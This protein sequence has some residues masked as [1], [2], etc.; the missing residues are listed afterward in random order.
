MFSVAL[1]NAACT[2]YAGGNW[3]IDAADIC[4]NSSEIIHLSGNLTVNGVL[5]LTSV[6]LI[7][8]TTYNGSIGVIVNAGGSLKL[9]DTDGDASTTNDA[10]NL[11][12]NNSVYRLKFESY[13]G[14]IMTHGF[15]SHIGFSN[16]DNLIN[17]FGIAL[18]SNYSNFTYNTFSN[19]YTG[20]FPGS[21]DSQI[22]F[23]N[24]SYNT[25]N[26]IDATSIRLQNGTNST[27][28][29]NLISANAGFAAIYLSYGS[30][31][32]RV[33]NNSFSSLSGIGV[34]VYLS[35]FNTIENNA[36]QGGTRGI[37]IE[38][39]HN[40]TVTNNTVN[41]STLASMAVYD[42]ENSTIQNN[43][44][45]FSTYDG[46]Y[47]NN[48]S[49][50]YLLYN[51]I[52]NNSRYG[53]YE[54]YSTNNQMFA[55]TIRYNADDGIAVYYSNYST[56]LANSVILPS[57]TASADTAGIHLYAGYYNVLDTNSITKAARQLGIGTS[58]DS[59]AE[60]S[61]NRIYGNNT[62]NAKEVR[63][64]GASEYACPDDASIA[65]GDSNTSAIY[66]VGCD[67]VTVADGTISNG[68]GIALYFTNNSRVDNATVNDS[69]TGAFYYRTENCT[70][71]DSTLY[72][73][74]YGAYSSFNLN[75]TMQR[76]AVTDVTVGFYHFASLLGE[77]SF[78]NVTLADAPALYLLLSIE[79]NFSYNNFTNSLYGAYLDLVSISNTFEA[80]NF[81]YNSIA[82]VYLGN[83]ES[84]VFINNDVAFNNNGY[85]FYYLQNDIRL[86][87]TIWNDRVYNNTVGVY[88]NN[89]SGN[90][91]TGVL[92]DNNSFHAEFN[93]S[94]GNYIANSTFATHLTN[95]TRSNNSASDTLLNNTGVDAASLGF[96]DS[97]SNVTLAYFVNVNVL[98][99]ADHSALSAA[100]SVTSQAS[101]PLY[102]FTSPG[103]NVI[104]PV[105]LAQ[106]ASPV[107]YTPHSFTASRSGFTP[108]TESVSVDPDETV[109]IYLVQLSTGTGSSA[110]STPSPT[111][112]PSPAA[113]ATASPTATIEAAAP[114]PTYA[115]T[116]SPTVT[117]PPAPSTASYPTATPTGQVKVEEEQDFTLILIALIIVAAIV[118]WLWKS[119]KKY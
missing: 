10:F 97:L 86:D 72:N 109:T 6:T 107:N 71:T 63:Y 5:H 84:N 57:T 37:E 33:I 24:L 89:A 67:N 44:F 38:A 51:V 52:E 53:I 8:N 50:G 115:A 13:G 1:A 112:T 85:S 19:M 49:Y 40:N 62:V 20:V 7:A 27:I 91:F 12:A 47:L 83:A 28:E 68:D 32:N 9:N 48:A 77:F 111:P 39:A 74:T 25:F 54:Y 66:V 55:N 79:N 106:M 16:H 108:A 102:S 87:N 82:G 104:T 69:W 23:T 3:D 105:Y 99:W 45:S 64:F 116:P 114:T 76:N 61:S 81:S 21:D 95:Q 15:V 17:N 43:T 113:T 60:L 80:N 90:N 78:N 96:E 100:V 26:N 98:S 65:I 42:S 18:F 88:L 46:A 103:S 94:L 11:T 41:A 119:F 118:Y 14:L 92:F 75:L 58:I 31:Y 30:H 35:D 56:I 29:G 70:L 93:A 59:E 117:E 4:A 2:G 101:Q 36:F 110:A 73:N 22:S 34:N